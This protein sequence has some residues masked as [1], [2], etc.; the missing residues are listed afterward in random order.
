M[1]INN[2]QTGWIFYYRGTWRGI[3]YAY[4]QWHKND[5]NLFGGAGGGGGAL[6]GRCV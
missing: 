6:I 3:E 1:I 5:E 2:Y 4:H